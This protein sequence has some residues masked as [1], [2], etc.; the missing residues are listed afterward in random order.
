MEHQQV[1]DNV[2]AQVS[3]VRLFFICEIDC[4]F[5]FATTLIECV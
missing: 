4:V 5:S 2:L 3:Q 1:S